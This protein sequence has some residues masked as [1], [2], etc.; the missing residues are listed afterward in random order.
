MKQAVIYYRVS[1][2]RQGYSG[3]GLKAQRNAV[4]FFARSHKY[5]I[6]KEFKEVESTRKNNT[7]RFKLFTALEVCK[8]TKATLLIAKLDRLHRSV[9]FIS[10]LMESEVDFVAV[11]NPHANKLMLHIMAAFAEHERDQISTRTKEALAV[12]KSKGVKLGKY[13]KNVL[14]KKNK[15]SADKF[16][17]K[18]KP[19]ISIYYQQGHRSVRKLATILNMDGITP[20]YGKK[21]KWHVTTVYNLLQRIKSL[22]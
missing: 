8:L 5:K 21:A 16:A 1:T 20:Y 11:D 19:V 6:I 9:S 18:M 10:A 22:D 15:R 14:S 17:R 3:L 2:K 7:N 4:T 12:A 13:G